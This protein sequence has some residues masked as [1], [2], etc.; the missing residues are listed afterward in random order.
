MLPFSRLAMSSGPLQHGGFGFALRLEVKRADV[1]LGHVGRMSGA[2]SAISTVGS[3]VGTF[4]TALYLIPA[5]GTARTTYLFAA[6]LIVLGLIGLRDWRYLLMLLVVA[7]LA[8]FTL[9]SRGNIK[10]ADCSGCNLIHE[11]ESAYNYRVIIGND[12]N[13]CRPA[14]EAPLPPET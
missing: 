10:S 13:P 9:T 4:L 11:E 5:I 7:A 3:I 2:I 12:Y 14:F 8:F 1:G 6:F